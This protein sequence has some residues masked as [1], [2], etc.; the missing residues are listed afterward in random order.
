MVGAGPY[1]ACVG[2]L[3][4]TGVVAPIRAFAIVVG[5]FNSDSLV[6]EAEPEAITTLL[7]SP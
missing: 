2:T 5:C 1:A 4:A 3:S 7:H 6:I